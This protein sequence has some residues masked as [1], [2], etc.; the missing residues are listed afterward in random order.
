MDKNKKAG[1]ER[2]YT[3]GELLQIICDTAKE[4]KLDYLDKLDY[5]LAHNTDK[6][7]EGLY[8]SLNSKTDYG[9]N[10]G[11]YSDFYIDGKRESVFTA[12]TLGESDD[13]YVRMHTL[14]A[15]LCLIA[16]KF[17]RTHKDEFNW[18]GYDVC[19]EKDGKVTPC[20]WTP[21][22]QGA[23]KHETYLKEKGYKTSIRNNA[24]REYL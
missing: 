11:I 21:D 7:V 14:A 18:N 4:E 15:H 17:F 13:D 24:T 19:Y 9:G 22:L 2:P 1:T 3:F 10:E 23:R 20:M 5:I 8:L 6:P 12:K 16:N